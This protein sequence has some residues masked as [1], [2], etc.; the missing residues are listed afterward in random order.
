MLAKL[1]SIHEPV[2]D[3]STQGGYRQG[4]AASCNAHGSYADHWPL[5]NFL[6][7]PSLFT[8]VKSGQSEPALLAAL[9]SALPA[10]CDGTFL[11]G[12]RSRMYAFHGIRGSVTTELLVAGTGRL[13]RKCDSK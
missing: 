10:A 11:E 4:A 12:N 3:L 1:G 6:A 8:R 13:H 2:K 7:S 5:A 9:E